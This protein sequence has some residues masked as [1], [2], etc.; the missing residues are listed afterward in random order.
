[1]RT[2]KIEMP[3]HEDVFYRSFR[4]PAGEVQVRLTKL[5]IEKLE[6]SDAYEIELHAVP[7]IMR[8]AQLA[9]ALN[10]VKMVHQRTL[11]LNYL[12]YGRADRRFTEG[13]SFGLSVFFQML[14]VLDFTVIWTFD[15]HNESMLYKLA[16][17]FRL[18]VVNTKP[19]DDQDDQIQACLNRMRKTSG[20]PF[21][22]MALISPDEGASKRYDLSKY[23]MKIFVGGK[24]RDPET[25][26]LNGFHIDKDI[27]GAAAAL[28][29]DDICDGGGTFIGLAEEIR[30]V[31][32]K[33]QLG[34]Y[35]SHGIYSK[36]LGPLKVQFDWVFTSDHTFRAK[37]G[38]FER[39][40]PPQFT[41]GLE[42]R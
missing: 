10:H 25:G 24:H 33:I 20:I 23:D 38:E 40:N 28:I 29:V 15:A 32:P 35:T 22:E 31:N 34:L 11:I 1:M 7:D 17:D 13:D 41:T 27:V 30:K 39:V 42:K 37:G 26:K 18:N 3:K 21:E 6:A 14:V 16:T 36:G 2:M 4:Y 12:P 8:L 9:D 19:T 5:G